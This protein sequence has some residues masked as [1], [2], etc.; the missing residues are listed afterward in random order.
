[1]TDRTATTGEPQ[2]PN[3]L[4]LCIDQWDRHMDLPEGVDLPA[5]ERLEA[6]GVSFDRHYCTVPICTPSRATMWTGQHA[7]N[8]DLWDNTNF[9][10]ITSGGLLPQT[11][12]LGTMLREQGYYT[13]FKGKWHLS[14]SRPGEDML[15]EYGFADYQAWG[16]MFGTPLQGEMLDGTVAMHTVDWLEHTAPTLDR[17]WL[18]I[19]SMVNPHDIMYF[20]SD[21]DAEFPDGGPAWKD[22]LHTAQHLG[23]FR[24]WNPDLPANLHDDLSQQPE[25]VRSYQENIRLVYGA[26]PA[27][28]EDLWRARR[29]YL[30]NCMRL[31][32]REIARILDAMDRQSHWENTVVIYTSD[33]GE[34]NGAHRMHQKGAIHFDEAAI[35]NLTA[36]VPGG[37]RGQRTRA[38]GSH[39]DL[40]P[41]LLDFAGVSEAERRRRYPRL[42]G[43]SLRGAIMEPERAGPRGSAEEPGDGALICWDGL[44]MLDPA[45]NGTGAISELTDLGLDKGG[46]EA[47]LRNVGAEYGA[48]DFS[49]RTFFRAV[50]DGRHKLVRWFSPNEYGNPSTLQELYA[51]GDVTLH[52]LVNDP[53]ELE[54]I[55]NPAHPNH[56]PA[57]VER[58]LAKLHALVRD[59][60]GEDRAPFDLDLFGTREVTYR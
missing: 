29:N 5:L 19:S 1:M 52:D 7:K 48:P 10:W 8:V 46:L 37:P 43:R 24:D 30:I 17:P 27:G 11:P 15:E 34:M 42:A 26:P 2:R 57:L 55:G 41:T 44:N 39:L 6:G 59:E 49:K 53:G 16:D 9:A 58:M 22:K 38:V 21:V 3:I 35:V 47:A 23:Y 28:R 54:N 33:H 50:V 56:D 13:A 60:I 45:W 4:V 40:V 36:V 12:T 18:L 32:D 31:V 20:Y 14:E 51:T 25:G